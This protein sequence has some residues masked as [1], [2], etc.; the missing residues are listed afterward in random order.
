MFVQLLLT[1]KPML[2]H[3]LFLLQNRFLALVLPI[4]TELDE[5]LHTAIVVWNTLVGRLRPRS[6]RGRL[7]AKL[8][9][10]FFVINLLVTRPKSYIETTD[11]RDFGGKPSKWRWGRVLSWKIPEFYSVS[12]ARFKNSIFSRFRVPFD[13]HRTAYRKQFYPKPMV[14]IESRGSEC[15]HFANLESLWPGIRHIL[16]P[17]AWTPTGMGKRGHLPPL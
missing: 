1:A 11:R 10:L 16:A 3:S 2:G 9:R 17:E 12:G 7:Q 6:A 5:I 14:P 4:S 13:Y 8:E 15:V